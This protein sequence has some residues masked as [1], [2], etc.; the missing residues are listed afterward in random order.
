MMFTLGLIVGTV[1]TGALVFFGI[2]DIK[3]PKDGKLA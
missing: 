2:V 3:G 1:T